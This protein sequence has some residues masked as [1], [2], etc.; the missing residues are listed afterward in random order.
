NGDRL[1]DPRGKANPVELA[2]PGSR[3]VRIPAA[4]RQPAHR[5]EE[6][7][8][9]WLVVQEASPAIDHGFD[10]PAAA[11]GEDR[12][13]GSHR[14]D[15]SDPE[16][17]LSGKDERTAGRHQP[18]DLAIRKGT[19]DPD[20]RSRL[21]AEPTLPGPRPDHEQWQPGPVAG[22]DHGID[23]L[24]G[25]EARDNQEE[26]LV[27]RFLPAEALGF[28]RGIHY[29]GPPAIRHLVPTDYH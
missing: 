20:G 14:L 17:F 12:L 6:R 25:V 1:V 28:D 29:Q 21:S 23:P 16:V 26:S 8:W 24:V 9:R 15:G 7:I 4:G 10:G 11:Q 3:E 13:A 18:V 2:G 27:A 22:R 19:R 5:V